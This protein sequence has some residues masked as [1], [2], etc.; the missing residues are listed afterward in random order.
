MTGIENQSIDDR[1]D[2]ARAEAWFATLGEVV[3][4]DVGVA[5]PACA[6]FAYFWNPVGREDLGTDGHAANGVERS[7]SELPLRMW[8]GGRLRWHAAFRAGIAAKRVTRPIGVT[9]KSGRSG[10]LDFV[11]LRHEIFQ[12]GALVL[13]EDR[14]IVYREA[15]ALEPEGPIEAGEA[16]ERRALKLDA[17]TLFQFSALTFNAHRI[18]YDTEYARD[19]GYGGVV[20]QGPLLATCLAGFAEERLGA[21][22]SFSF[23]ATAPL[24]LGDVAWLC[25]AGAR[26]WVEGP[27]RRVSMTAEATAA[28]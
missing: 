28:K 17:A 3:R 14:D 25:R 13:S 23:R 26:Y 2:P 1:I 7:M 6:H 9:R 8:A 11:T 4:V 22:A 20:V 27:R 12:R 21:L 16:D 24:I 19:A 15:V 5:L 18:H 10:Q